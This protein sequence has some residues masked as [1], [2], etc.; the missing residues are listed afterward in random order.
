LISFAPV[1]AQ[2][3]PV[4]LK[5]EYRINPIG[6]DIKSPRFSWRLSTS[7]ANARGVSQS[8]YRVIVATDRQRLRRNTADLWDSGKVE[9]SQSIQVAY[10]GKPLTSGIRAFW[11]VRIWD[12]A[13]KQSPWSEP[14]F[15]SEGL[16]N[17]DDWTAKWIGHDEKELW[18]NPHSPFRYLHDAHW[19]WSSGQG[20]QTFRTKISIPRGSTPKDALVVMS[21][22]Q[23]FELSLN[24]EA[25]G[26]S[27]TV[28]APAVW[29]V[30]H[31]FKTGDNDVLVRVKRP[32]PSS[33]GLI[34]TF[35]IELQQGNAL[36]VHTD[37]TWTADNA[38][39]S[40]LGSYGCAPWGESGYIEERALPARM[41]RKEFQAAGA[42]KKAI[43]YVSGLGLSEFYVNGAKIGDE[44]LSPGLTDY[45][46]RVQYVTYDLTGQ[47]KRG[48]NAIGLILGNGRFWA[49]RFNVA[50]PT[51]SFGYPKARAQF[52]IEYANG[53]AQR[54]VSDETWK[55]TTDG[56]I[57]ANNEYD[58]EDYN[59]TAEIAGWANPGFDDSTWQAAELV[60]APAGEMAAQN[61]EPMQVTQTIKPVKVT[62]LRPGAYIF[63]MGQNMVGWCR[64]HVA[65]PRGTT[66]ELHHAETLQPDGELYTANLRSARATDRYTLK[67]SGEEVWE[68][69][70]TYHGF[71]YV[72]V[73][74]YPGVPDLNSIEGRVVHDA[75]FETAD[76]SSS[77][78]MLNQIHSNVFW[79]V[80]GNYRSIPTDCPQRD[81]RQGW[82]GDRSVVSRSESY[83]FNIAAFYD[84]WERDLADSQ[85]PEGG[86]PD[87]SPTYWSIYND[88]VTWPST[89][90]QV[91]SM[92][93]DQYADLRV[94][95]EN[96][97]PMNHW[98]D[99]MKGLMQDGLLPKDMYGDWCVPPENPKLIHS[100]D[101]ARRTD[102]TLL[103]TA[104]FYWMN[105]QMARFARLIGKEPDAAE[106][107]RTAEEIKTAFNNAY[108]HNERGVYGNNTQTANILPLAFGLV[109]PEN[110][111][112]VFD[113]L[114]QD[115]ETTSNGH[116]G[117]GLVGA[118]WLMR[119]LSENGRP[120]VALQIATQP[121]YPGWG[122]MV[123]KGAT[124]VWELWNGDTAD[125][126]M[127]SGN[128][129]MQ[130][131]DLGLWMYEDLAGIRPDPENPG[132]KHILIHPYPV[133]ELTFV[134]ASHKS[135]YGSI[136]SHWKRENGKLTLDVTIPANT[137]A[138][139]WVPAQSAADVSES[140]ISAAR[141]RCVKFVRMDGNA[142]VF[143]VESGSYSF[144]APVPDLN[145]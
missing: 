15:W 12:E 7:D 32:S 47:V 80:R 3:R 40:D 117:T 69:R 44:V 24:G 114:I 29:D 86:I 83:L 139:V 143:E 96:Y 136:S 10:A 141:A 28:G 118:Q 2:V 75:M 60:Q 66:V 67:G 134:K 99:H 23:E 121:T 111:Q 46:K 92:L 126:A 127:N 115:I 39:V 26:K 125:P 45:D 25:V 90:V 76:F 63:D 57:R 87:V 79:G 77:S 97:G 122:Y 16:L 13:G 116:V 108:F 21:A 132:F 123:T 102:G 52:E 82:L 8:A 73:K 43:A 106:F 33:P 93:Y 14:A 31:F 49:P 4:D 104:Y 18:K 35:H 61:A 88:D 5:C 145:P 144:S 38:S 103:A 6:I 58:G 70:F 140:G 54:V 68:P 129:V 1:L 110:K 137:T 59:A 42:V 98:I 62:E 71:R 19:I 72:E 113:A 91:P 138:T 135:L 78:T 56:P 95:Q 22:D 85:N 11:K 74:G 89:F 105:R 34:G 109:A 9:W 64:L 17:A 112:R 48:K 100:L 30:T 81:E 131:G 55:L 36:D 65:G 37:Q 50:A 107:D 84:K 20:P 27:G 142:A 41:L 51:R 133:K 53:T 120:D 101:P 128:H 94:I 124:T 130:I 119:T